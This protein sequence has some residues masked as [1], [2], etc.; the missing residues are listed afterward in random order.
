MNHAAHATQFKKQRSGGT[1]GLLLLRRKAPLSRRSVVYFCS[2]AHSQLQDSGAL[3]TIAQYLAL[4]QDAYLVA[5]LEKYATQVM[6]R[7]AAPPKIVVLNNALLTA[8]HPQ[9]APDP[10][11]DPGRFGQWVE[12]ACLAFAVNQNQQVTYWR[13]EPIEV[14]GVFEGSWG[15]WAVEI[16]TGGFTGPD[17]RGLLEFCRRNSEFIPLV[18]TAP[19]DEEYAVRHGI[20]VISW[21]DYLLSGPPSL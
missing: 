3:E 5:P 20:R 10:K 2:G 1:T 12:N 8:T 19:D 11:K 13:E 14:D 16:K 17:L 9:G 18:I 21:M 6:R 7:R 4:L 15:K